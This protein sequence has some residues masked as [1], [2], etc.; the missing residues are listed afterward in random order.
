MEFRFEMISIRIVR[1]ENNNRPQTEAT[2]LAMGT[3]Y[4]LKLSLV[5]DVL[6]GAMH[7]AV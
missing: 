5:A 7:G 4:C 2:P 3:M 6:M 1:T